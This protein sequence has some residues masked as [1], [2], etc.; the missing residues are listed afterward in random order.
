M[1]LRRPLALRRW[2]WPPPSLRP[3]EGRKPPPTR[4]RL[5]SSRRLGGPW[6]SAAELGGTPAERD[7]GLEGRGSASGAKMAAVVALS[8]GAGSRPP[9]SAG[10]ACRCA[11]A[12]GGGQGWREGRGDGLHARAAAEVEGGGAAR[13][14]A[15][16]A[17]PR[18]VLMPASCSSPPPARWSGRRGTIEHGGKGWGEAPGPSKVTWRKTGD[19]CLV[20]VDANP[21]VPYAR[22]LRR[23]HTVT[24][25][26]DRP[27]GP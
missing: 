14:G 9:P 7:L 22:S 26:T 23:P 2:R 19:D 11:A 12:R 15:R 6:R 18:G 27:A 5:R 13:G 4:R 17:P 3:L 24:A 16:P 25:G 10:P 8:L 20:Q 1:G 21:S